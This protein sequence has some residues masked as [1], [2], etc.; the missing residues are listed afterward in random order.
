MSDIKTRE[1]M[2]K[3]KRN[4]PEGNKDNAGYRRSFFKCFFFNVY[5]FL[6]DRE[7]QRMS[8]GGAERGGRG[9]TQNPKRAPGSELSAHAGLKSTSR[10]IMTLAKVEHLTK[11]SKHPTI[12]KAKFYE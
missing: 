10:E 3:R 6:R 4:D 5:L 11:S 12:L 1:D 8:R 7:R 2:I 9:E